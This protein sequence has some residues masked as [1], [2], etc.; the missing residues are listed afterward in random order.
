VS[1][2]P[3]RIIKIWKENNTKIDEGEEWGEIME[4]DWKQ[5]W[6]CKIKRANNGHAHGRQRRQER[7][8]AG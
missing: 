5:F 3:S 8:K 6:V 4:T 2:R 1:S 7:E